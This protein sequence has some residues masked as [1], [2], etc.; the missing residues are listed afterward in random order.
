MK[1]IVLRI[2]AVG[3]LVFAGAT[4]CKHLPQRES[5]EAPAP[6]PESPFSERVAAV[7]LVEANTE[8]FSIGI[9][10]AGIVAQVCVSAGQR[11]SAG[12]VLFEIDNRHL[13]ADETNARGEPRRDADSSRSIPAERTRLLGATSSPGPARLF[14]GEPSAAIMTT[15]PW[16]LIPG[17]LVPLL[18]AV[19]I[20]I[21]VR[22]TANAPRSSEG[23]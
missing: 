23:K 18:F 1:N 3:A 4:L 16:L 15:L 20:G 11:V 2:I 6:P 5:T 9:N 22:L 13:R 14:F 17:F 12:D 19:H 7:V 8:N 21:H 10:I